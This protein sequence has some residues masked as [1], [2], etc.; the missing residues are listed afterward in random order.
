MTS[1]SNLGSFLCCVVVGVTTLEPTNAQVIPP[2][3]VAKL[4]QPEEIKD[5]SPSLSIRNCMRIGSIMPLGL[6]LS[7]AFLALKS[8]NAK[9]ME[10]NVK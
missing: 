2:T 1:L 3:D 4:I 6:Y 5:L 9:L 10:V 7:Q 8:N